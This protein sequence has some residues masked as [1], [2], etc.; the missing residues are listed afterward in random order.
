MED[1]VRTQPGAPI[2][3][4]ALA[5]ALVRCGR[6]E[7]A[8][9]PFDWL[10]ADDCARVPSDINFPGILGGLGSVC[11]A[12]DADKATA[13]SIYDQLLPHAGTFNW[14]LSFMSRSPTTWGWPA[15]PAAAGEL[16]VAD[17][18]FAASVELCERLGARPDLAWTH[19][20]WA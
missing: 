4:L 1:L 14:G 8:R 5:A 18:H 12:L 3:R 7:E 2:W 19:H 20:D 6:L 10:A 11:L 9:V 15:R 13:A 17:R 16:E